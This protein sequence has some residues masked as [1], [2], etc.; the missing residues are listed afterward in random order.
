MPTAA[1]LP[2]ATVPRAAAP[3]RV[4]ELDSRLRDLSTAARRWAVARSDQARSTFAPAC[5]GLADAVEEPTARQGPTASLRVVGAG[6][7]AQ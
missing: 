5:L 1:A 6:G 4:A 3:A 7:P 2:A